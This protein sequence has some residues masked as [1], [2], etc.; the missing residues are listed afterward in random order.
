MVEEVQTS[1]L[2]GYLNKNTTN[3]GAPQILRFLYKSSMLTFQVNRLL[4]GRLR[5]M[6]RFDCP[7]LV[8]SRMTIPIWH[9]YL[10]FIHR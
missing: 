2:V 3:T 9:R 1:Q 6:R 4:D 5:W 10:S 8:T 7:F